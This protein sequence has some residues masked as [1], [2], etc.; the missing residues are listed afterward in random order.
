MILIYGQIG[1][2][3]KSIRAVNKLCSSSLLEITRPIPA[4]SGLSIETKV[5]LDWAMTKYTFHHDS[6]DYR[7]ELTKLTV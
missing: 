5:D 3:E 7:R 2:L 1:R 4:C 6:R